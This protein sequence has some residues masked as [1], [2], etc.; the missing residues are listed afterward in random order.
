MDTH[1]ALRCVM[2]DFG[3]TMMYLTRPFAEILDEGNLAVFEFVRELGSGIGFGEYA[4]ME[5]RIFAKY[6]SVEELENR[7]IPDAE[8]YYAVAAELF[9]GTEAAETKTISLAM[10]DLFWEV[11]SGYQLPSPGLADVLSELKK[12]GKKLGIV[13]NHH[14]GDALREWLAKEDLERF[15][16]AVVISSEV[17]FR[18]PDSRIFRFALERLA[19][20]P[21]E[22]VFVGDDIRNDMVG[23]GSVGMKTVLFCGKQAGL[24]GRGSGAQW[25]S[26]LNFRELLN[27]F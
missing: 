10:R 22:T 23:A 24:Y 26:I 21:H 7:D 17:G 1:R 15:F 16:D 27:I 5:S 18:K 20:L 3:G 25:Q 6:K 12:G 14:N 19:A 9:P 2:L 4:E 13:S 11:V 8:K